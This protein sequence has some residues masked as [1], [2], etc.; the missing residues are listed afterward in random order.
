MHSLTNFCSNNTFG[1]LYNNLLFCF[2]SHRCLCYWLTQHATILLL[3]KHES[4]H[5]GD[6]LVVVMVTFIHIWWD[7]PSSRP[8]CV[9]RWRFWFYFCYF[10]PLFVYFILSHCFIYFGSPPFVYFC[11]YN[12]TWQVC[13]AVKQL[14]FVFYILYKNC[15]TQKM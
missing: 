11:L 7:I 13:V 3:W 2:P 15:I 6:R 14:F 5:S 10:I 4:Q 8:S 12:N 1:K 9:S